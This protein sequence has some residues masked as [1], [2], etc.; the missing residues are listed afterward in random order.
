MSMLWQSTVW[1]VVHIKPG[2]MTMERCG[3][4]ISCQQTYQG[5]ESSPM[6]TIRIL[7]S[8]VGLADLEIMPAR[9]W[10]IFDRREHLLIYA[11][12]IKLEVGQ[13]LKTQ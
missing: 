8:H 11:V 13:L 1:A 9:F 2:H 12:I 7:S 3:Y 5:H 10:R 6:V 4:V